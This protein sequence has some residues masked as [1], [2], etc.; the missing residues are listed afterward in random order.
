MSSSVGGRGMGSVGCI[1]DSSV[2]ERVSSS[3][4]GRVRGTTPGVA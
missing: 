1:I 3:V 2:D 4:G